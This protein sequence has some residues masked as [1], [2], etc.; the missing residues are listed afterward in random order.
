MEFDWTVF[1]VGVAAGFGLA[2][3]YGFI[4]ACVDDNRPRW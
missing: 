2:V 3:L 4:K 1:F